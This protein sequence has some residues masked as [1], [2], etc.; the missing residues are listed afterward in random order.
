VSL[1]MANREYRAVTGLL[2]AVL[3]LALKAT[4]NGMFWR[5]GAGR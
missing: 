1:A 2:V 4:Y 3:L 5:A